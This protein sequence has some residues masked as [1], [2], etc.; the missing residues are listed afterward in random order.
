M[1]VAIG[2]LVPIGAGLAGILLGPRMLEPVAIGTGDLDSH[3][4]YLSGLL[5][6]IGLGF[7]S[8]ISRIETRGAR[9]RLLTAIVVAGGIGRLAGVVT[10]GTPSTAMIAALAMELLVTPGLA[11]WQWRVATRTAAG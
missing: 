8:T 10:I 6:G 4:R 11:F 7:V 9:F 1:A 3:F 5:L 2:C